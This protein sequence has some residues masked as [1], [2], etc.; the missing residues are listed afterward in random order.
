MTA[1]QGGRTVKKYEIPPGT[2]A[3]ICKGENCKQEIFWVTGERGGAMCV[4]PD[5]TPH[6][7]TCPDRFRFKRGAK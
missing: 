1:D 5:G 4:D 6:W 7:A 3:V 2:R